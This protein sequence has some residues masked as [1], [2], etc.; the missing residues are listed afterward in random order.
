[1]PSSIMRIQVNPTLFLATAANV[2]ATSKIAQI[3]GN[4]C[5][6]NRASGQKIFVQVVRNSKK[7]RSTIAQEKFWCIIGNCFFHC[8][9]MVQYIIKSLTAILTP[10]TALH[11]CLHPSLYGFQSATPWMSDPA[12]LYPKLMATATQKNSRPQRHRMPLCPHGI[13]CPLWF[14]GVFL[15]EPTASGKPPL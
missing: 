11:W 14:G 10:E 7:Q 6:R 12:N 3:A 2:L 15:L 9:F 1:M 5:V 4:A 13:L 8:K